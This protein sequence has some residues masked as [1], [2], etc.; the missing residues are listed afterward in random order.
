M[1]INCIKFCN[2]QVKESKDIKRASLDLHTDR[3]TQN[4]MPPFLKG[5]GHKNAFVYKF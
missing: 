4:N 3:Q 2:F 5:G 1:D